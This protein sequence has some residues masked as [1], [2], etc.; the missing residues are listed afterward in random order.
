[1]FG[2]KATK[3]IT[4]LINVLRRYKAT[5]LSTDAL[6]LAIFYSRATHL[7]N[8][9]HFANFHDNA[10]FVFV[11]FR[12]TRAYNLLSVSTQKF[13]IFEYRRSSKKIIRYSRYVI[14]YIWY[15]HFFHYDSAVRQGKRKI[16]IFFSLQHAILVGGGRKQT[17]N[18]SGN[19]ERTDLGNSGHGET[20]DAKKGRTNK[21]GTRMTLQA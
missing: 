2:R 5:S 4:V 10:R 11:L 19:R 12:N 3:L 20:N 16:R 17:R 18:L 9:N 8:V 13:V 15:F 21:V 14:I 1:M 7:C 6:C